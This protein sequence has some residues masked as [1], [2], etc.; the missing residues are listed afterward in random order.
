MFRFIYNM[1]IY[2]ITQILY[3]Y[4]FSILTRNTIKSKIF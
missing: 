1:Y 3:T 4:K 2:I